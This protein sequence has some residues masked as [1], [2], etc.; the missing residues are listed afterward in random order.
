M[1]AVYY[2]RDHLNHLSFVNADDCHC[3]AFEKHAAEIGAGNSRSPDELST[4]VAVPTDSELREFDLIDIR[5]RVTTSSD[6]TERIAKNVISVRGC[7][8][9]AQPRIEL[10]RQRA[11]KSYDKKR[12]GRVVATTPSDSSDNGTCSLLASRPRLVSTPI[13][14]YDQELWRTVLSGSAR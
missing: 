8:G 4:C 13:G 2:P 11:K 7:L 12:C 1:P 6:A 14:C 5:V 10:R 9:E 3:A